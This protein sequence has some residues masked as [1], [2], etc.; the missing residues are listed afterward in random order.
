MY[1][2]GDTQAPYV[3]FEMLKAAAPRAETYVVDGDH[4]FICDDHFLHPEGKSL[5]RSLTGL[6]ERALLNPGSRGEVH[7]IAE[8]RI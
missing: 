3:S 1:S 5:F 6:F 4:H 7:R 8:N 2:K